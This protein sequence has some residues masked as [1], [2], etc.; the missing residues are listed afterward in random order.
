[1]L[2]LSASVST[3]CSITLSASSTLTIDLV[4]TKIK[5]D[6][7]DKGKSRLTKIFC[8]LFIILS[9]V[10]ANTKTPILDMMSYS[11]G[12]ISGS[13][14]APYV[15][16]LYSKKLN[17]QGAW[18][19]IIAGFVIAIIP[20]GCKILNLCGV[21]SSLVLK[22]LAQ[23]PL[24]ACIAMI[25]SIIMCLVVSFVTKNKTDKENVEFFYNGVVDNE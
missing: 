17:K 6:I 4:A 9:Y 7:D 1:M 12:I 16:A 10:V 19:G 21:N 23:G 13:F 8:V 2:L 24:Y 14:L 5:P 3:L 22:I 25:A 18:A 11:W 15:L 20:A